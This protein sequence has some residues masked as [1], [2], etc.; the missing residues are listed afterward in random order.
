MSLDRCHRHGGLSLRDA[1]AAW[2]RS[3]STLKHAPPSL[4]ARPAAVDHLGAGYSGW[5]WPRRRTDLMA[6]RGAGA[7]TRDGRQSS[8]NPAPRHGASLKAPRVDRVNCT[9]Q[10]TI[11]L[12][13]MHS[14][15]VSEHY[16]QVHS[17]SDG[18]VLMHSACSR[19]EEGKSHETPSARRPRK[20][21]LQNTA[22]GRFNR[23]RN[24]AQS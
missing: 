3:V 4:G 14:E 10:R 7:G 9:D 21:Q 6:A 13:P 5:R 22:H 16:I 11:T 17:V 8:T 12:A 15:R 2:A 20:L 18:L 19:L 24:K 1:L 23:G